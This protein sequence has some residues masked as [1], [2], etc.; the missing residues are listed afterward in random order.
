MNRSAFWTS[1]SLMTVSDEG[2]PSTAITSAMSV[3]LLSLC[4]LS[5]MTVMSLAS[6]LSIFA[7]WDPISPAP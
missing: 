4:G 1:A 2:D 3:M 6:W 7:R 5:S